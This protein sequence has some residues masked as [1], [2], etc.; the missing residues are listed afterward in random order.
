MIYLFSHTPCKGVTHIKPLYIEFVGLK[1]DF[2]SF[3]A[4]VFTSK[5][6]VFGLDK[7]WK[8]WI[9]LPSFAIGESTAGTIK[10]LGGYVE[11]ISNLSYGDDFAKEVAPFL[12]GKRV[13]YSRAKELVSDVSGILKQ[14]DI[15]IEELITYQ[16][17]CQPC[18]KLQKP[19]LKSVLIF[20]SPSSVH[21]FLK[22]FSWHG[23]WQAV[24]IGK[25]TASA[26]PKSAS[27]VVSD[28]RTVEACVELA[29][30]MENV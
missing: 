4:L 8:N 20:T 17:I 12:K 6:G 3:D 9:K 13:L 23:S 29:R 19:K 2:S 26:L 21:C 18:K 15:Q 22:C 24:C 7:L 11:F 30:D 14:H 1:L 28:I 25:K 16:S 10:E 27:Y 5:N